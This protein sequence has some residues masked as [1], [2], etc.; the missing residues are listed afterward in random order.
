MNNV[1]LLARLTRDPE[2]RHLKSGQPILALGLASDS[3]RFDKETKKYQPFFVDAEMF[4]ERGEKL[5]P[6]L[7]KGK[8]VV[9]TGS[10]VTSQWEAEGGKRS[11]IILDIDTLK[12]VSAPRSDNQQDAGIQAAKQAFQATTSP[13]TDDDIP[14]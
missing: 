5:A 2:I 1:T 10:F 13:V 4:G 12:F 14:F 8:Q 3:K 7:E 11:R 6:H 9:I